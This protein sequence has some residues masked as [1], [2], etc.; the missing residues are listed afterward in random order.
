VTLL[1]E[2]ATPEEVED[3]RG[4]VLAVAERVAAAKSEGDEPVSDSER[5]AVEAIADAL[6]RG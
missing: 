3:Y 1:E 4:F 2:K 6:G 5:A